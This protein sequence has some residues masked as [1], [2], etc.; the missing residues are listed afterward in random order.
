MACNVTCTICLFAAGKASWRINATCS[1][2]LY[3]TFS[4]RSG[5]RRGPNGHS[6]VMSGK[7]DSWARMNL[8]SGFFASGET[9]VKRGMEQRAFHWL[10][11]NNW[12]F[13]NVLGLAL[14]KI[15]FL[16]FLPC[17]P[18]L[19][20]KNYW[21]EMH[22]LDKQNDEENKSCFKTQ[23]FFEFVLKTSKKLSMG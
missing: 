13:H 5:Q 2:S 19:M 21:I 23:F 7:C 8:P 3:S 14:E 11:L 16:V 1:I 20:S 17:F 10:I 6:R 15:T 18:V 4:P 9:K 12:I 22:F